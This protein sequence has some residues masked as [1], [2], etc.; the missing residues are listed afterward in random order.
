MLGVSIRKTCGVVVGLVYF[1]VNCVGVYASES[2]FW[3]ER[4]QAAE[5]KKIPSVGCLASL[6]IVPGP[7]IPFGSSV[8]PGEEL[9]TVGVPNEIAKTLPPSF[10]Q[11]NAQ[12]LTALSSAEGSIRRI[13]LPPHDHP[14]T[15]I[16]HVQD[17]HLNADVQSRIGALVTAVHGQ[18]TVDFVGLEGAF[19]PLDFSRYR[20]FPRQETIGEVARVLLEKGDISGPIHAALAG[21]SAPPFFVGV[22]DYAQYQ[23][24]V[25]AYRASVPLQKAMRFRLEEGQRGL[26][27]QKAEIFSPGLLAFDKKIEDYRAGRLSLGDHLQSLASAYAQLPKSISNFLTVW[28]QEKEINFKQA[29]RDRQNLL[30]G[31]ASKVDTPTLTSLTA[32]AAACRAGSKTYAA[33]YRQL[34]DVCQQAGLSIQSYPALAAYIRYVLAADHIS[35]D[36]LFRDMRWTEEQAYAR[37]VKTEEERILVGKS[38]HVGLLKK[39]VAFS[40]IPEEWAEYIKGKSQWKIDS[41]NELTPFENFYKE[42]QARDDSMTRNFLVAMGTQRAKTALLV[43]G[44]FH[45]AGMEERFLQAGAAVVSF[46]PRIDQIGSGAGTSYL[47][48]FERE[49]TPLDR[50]FQGRTLFLTPEIFSPTTQNGKAPL[51]AAALEAAHGARGLDELQAKRTF[52]ALSSNPGAPKA[53]IK[54]IRL[55]DNKVGVTVEIGQE[56]STLWVDLSPENDRILAYDV[57]GRGEERTLEKAQGI[58]KKW[59]GRMASPAWVHFWAGITEWNVLSKTFVV[60]HH[61]RTAQEWIDQIENRRTFLWGGALFLISILFLAGSISFVGAPHVILKDWPEALLISFPLAGVGKV[62]WHMALDTYRWR[63]DGVRAVKEGDSSVGTQLIDAVNILESLGREPSVNG[64]PLTEFKGNP[65]GLLRHLEKYCLVQHP[66]AVLRILNRMI[67]FERSLE[68]KKRVESRQDLYEGIF[69]QKKYL[70]RHFSS[71]NPFNIVNIRG[72][73]AAGKFAEY[74]HQQPLVRLTAALSGG[75]SGRS[76]FVT[77]FFFGMPGIADVGKALLNLAGY[78]PLKNFLGKRFKDEAWTNMETSE[79]EFLKDFEGLTEYLTNGKTTR[80]S[81]QI[82]GWKKDVDEL[83]EPTRDRLGLFFSTFLRILKT[84]HAGYLIGSEY[85]NPEI[86]PFRFNN[87]PFRSIAILGA[88]WH[89]QAE[90]FNDPWQKAITDIS[91]MLKLRPGDSVHLATASPQHIMG[92]TEDGKVFL[93]DTGMNEFPLEKEIVWSGLVDNI[94]ASDDLINHFR[95]ET[96]LT[97]ERFTREELLSKGLHE[98]VVDEIMITSFKLKREE[99]TPDNIKKTAAFF[100]ARSRSSKQADNPVVVHDETKRALSTAQAIVYGPG[101]K[102]TSLE[103]ATLARGNLGGIDKNKKSIKILF[104]N[105]RQESEVYNTNVEREVGH[106]FRYLSGQGSDFGSPTDWEKG[107]QRLDLVLGMDPAKYPG[108][109][110]RGRYIPFSSQMVRDATGEKVPGIGLDLESAAPTLR[111]GTD[112]SETQ[113]F[114]FDPAIMLESIISAYAIRSA[115]YALEDSGTLK[116]KKNIPEEVAPPPFFPPHMEK[117]KNRMKELEW[118]DEMIRDLMGEMKDFNI[119]SQQWYY[120]RLMRRLGFGVS[121]WLP[122]CRSATWAEMTSRMNDLLNSVTEC[123]AFDKDDTLDPR[124]TN[125]SAKTAG[126]LAKRIAAGQKIAIVTA[127]SLEEI[128]KVRNEFTGNIGI[129]IFGPIR[130][131][132][133]K[134]L[135]SETKDGNLHSVEDQAEDLLRDLFYLFL[136]TGATLARLKK[137]GSKRTADLTIDE[138]FSVVY[139]SDLLK[140]IQTLLGFQKIISEKRSQEAG[141]ENHPLKEMMIKQFNA[142]RLAGEFL[143]KLTFAPF[144][145]APSDRGDREKI[146]REIDRMF[147]TFNIPVS[148]HAAGKSSI[149]FHLYVNGHY[150]EK[151]RALEYLFNQGHLQVTYVDNEVL[152]GNG[153][154]SVDLLREMDRFPEKFN[155]RSLR[156]VSVDPKVNLQQMREAL[157]PATSSIRAF[158]AAP[159]PE[160]LRFRGGSQNPHLELISLDGLN[161]TAAT[162][163]YLENTSYRSVS[164]TELS[165]GTPVNVSLVV[166]LHPNEIVGKMVRVDEHGNPGTILTTHSSRGGPFTI[167]PDEVFQMVSMLRTQ[168]EISGAQ[169]DPHIS[170]MR[171]P[172]FPKIKMDDLPGILDRRKSKTVTFIFPSD[173]EDQDTSKPKPYSVREQSAKAVAH[174]IFAASGA[175]LM[176]SHLLLGFGTAWAIPVAILTLAIYFRFSWKAALAR[177]EHRRLMAEASQWDPNRDPIHTVKS[178]SLLQTQFQRFGV[179]PTPAESGSFNVIINGTLAK[180]RLPKDSIEFSSLLGRDRLAETRRKENGYEIVIAPNIA[181]ALLPSVVLTEIHRISP[182]GVVSAFFNRIIAIVRENTPNRVR[183]ARL[184]RRDMRAFGVPESEDKPRPVLNLLMPPLES[185]DVNS[186]EGRTTLM[187]QTTSRMKAGGAYA[188]EWAGTVGTLVSFHQVLMEDLPELRKFIGSRPEQGNERF[189]ILLVP[190]A[191]D[192]ALETALAALA[193]PQ[194]GVLIHSF[195]PSG[196]VKIDGSSFESWARG[197]GTIAWITTKNPKAAPILSDPHIPLLADLVVLLETAPPFTRARLDAT[198]AFARAFL[199][200]A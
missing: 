122:E 44:G 120:A 27:A 87:F 74:V 50:M 18:K 162:A 108:L 85:R 111:E 176:V 175:A 193:G 43:T 161:E 64:H 153:A 166:E 55:P 144:G 160:A 138:I 154:S 130:E 15:L 96:G 66:A 198:A 69:E 191:N 104:T 72:G 128:S 30:E 4:R 149:D 39:L 20:A 177:N 37:L 199:T 14:S 156:V 10:F 1:A 86:P 157:G 32:E 147:K 9:S 185:L 123:L 8:S 70:E 68:G 169:I 75:D 29:E 134:E 97:L 152:E 61:P 65:E 80:S 119:K 129:E 105:P 56:T 93:V 155:G 106:F 11:E 183:I 19:G 34:G 41:S 88:V 98:S 124:N 131:A 38:R 112:Y 79:V 82:T 5:T 47:S 125:I 92:L 137:H 178:L 40:L 46:T 58:F 141:E 60:E 84:H 77:G 192:P 133:I 116:R 167:L 52:Q 51:L 145:P 189:Q 179:T 140:K 17:V 48:V 121:E 91:S 126:L 26:Q 100:S 25:D 45:S 57:K 110:P 151:R 101:S 135:Q 165:P 53:K 23:A 150:I 62:V 197:K 24:N 200:A 107:G 184:A 28:A 181:P 78:K 3:T 142:W 36:Q 114:G 63:T 13:R 190:G 42:A 31:L 35:P 90:G 195:D 182:L 118:S 171:G 89:Y 109:D 143:A 158:M 16:V 81:Y 163:A 159:T 7:P 54:A 139:P 33:F 148:P 59:T 21:P 180:V 170:V 95:Q 2:S 83:E 186:L 164:A 73:R 187:A 136:D 102:T 168:A 67:E 173:D 146:A 172:K 127:K 76:L 49:K 6:P 71:K 196:N 132:L 194:V 117:I 174:G 22:D 99:V 103:G 94:D 115:G 188:Q 12:L 113:E